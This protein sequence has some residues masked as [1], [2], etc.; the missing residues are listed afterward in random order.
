M[1]K[2]NEEGSFIE[3]GKTQEKSLQCLQEFRQKYEFQDEK[4]KTQIW[5]RIKEITTINDKSQKFFLSK[6][7]DDDYNPG[8]R[9]ETENKENDELRRGKR[10]KPLEL[11][12]PELKSVTVDLRKKKIKRNEG[13][14]KDEII[15]VSSRGEDEV[16]EVEIL[17]S[18]L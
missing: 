6:A 16:D 12:E 11:I 7:S 4:S 13:E 10:S 3:V 18:E 17:P 9:F 2:I 14:L 8:K 5:P 1:Q 15:S